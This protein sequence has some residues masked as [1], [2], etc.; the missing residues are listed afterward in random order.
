MDDSSL[1]Y[2]YTPEMGADLSVGYDTFIK[3]DDSKDEH[4]DGMLKAI[5]ELEQRTGKRTQADILTWRG[6]MTKLMT[7]PFEKFDGFDMRATRFQ[8]TIFIEEH[9]SSKLLRNANDRTKP[10]KTGTP[11]DMFQY[12]GYKFESLCLIPDSWDAT[13]RDYIES[14]GSHIVSNRAQYCS[15]VR[16]G[17]GSSSIIM[18][19]EVDAGMWENTISLHEIRDG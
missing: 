11:Q 7:A 13:S 9:H 14:R 12:W 1:R 15:I 4:L 3:Q 17:M 16:T 18:G 6:M 8:D 2:Y 10:S 5:M 19:G